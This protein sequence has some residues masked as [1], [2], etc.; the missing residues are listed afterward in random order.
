M[1]PDLLPA[2]PMSQVVFVHDYLQ[3]VFQGSCFSI[4][5][6][7]TLHEDGVLLEQGQ[8]GFCDKLVGLI[9]QALSMVS[10]IGESSLT[11]TFLNGAVLAVAPDGSGPEAWQF[12][13][14]GG[15]IVVE[16]NA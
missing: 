15:L 5:N 8:P 11:L 1:R 4:Y 13:S 16:Q 6:L 3:L 9:G 12:N 10:S 2:D 14:L 7:A